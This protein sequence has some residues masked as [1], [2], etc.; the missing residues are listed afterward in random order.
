MAIRL[1]DV[2]TVRSYSGDVK[3]Y[4]SYLI[5]SLHRVIGNIEA[6]KTNKIIEGEVANVLEQISADAYQDA[7]TFNTFLETF[8]KIVN[9]TADE[10]ERIDEESSKQLTS[11]TL[12]KGVNYNRN[13]MLKKSI[14]FD[15]TTGVPEVTKKINLGFLG[16][17]NS[18]GD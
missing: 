5:D 10:V 9:K 15:P 2:Q 3:T 13:G 14:S 12:L 1:V 4:G 16:F 7:Q 18:N 11:E 17:G 6:L 8:A